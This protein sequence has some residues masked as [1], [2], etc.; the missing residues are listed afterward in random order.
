MFFTRNY[1]LFFFAMLLTACGAPT[2]EGN[3]SAQDGDTTAVGEDQRPDTA[4]YRWTAYES[5]K[6]N[7]GL[8]RPADWRIEETEKSEAFT[9]VNI[10]SP[11]REA[12][13]ELPITIHADAGVSHVSLYPHGFGTELPSGDRATLD[14]F[15]RTAPVDFA[16]AH[17]ESYAFQLEN[18]QTWGY[19]LQPAAPPAGWSEQGFIFAQIAVDNFEARCFDE[20]TGEAI[21]MQACDPMT[22]D[23]IERSGTLQAAEQ[24]AV[25]RILRS[26][27]FPEDGT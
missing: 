12:A 17:E 9:M 20:A 10:F 1:T 19:L 16:L 18:G 5:R 25:R 4:T 22:G 3:S 8:Q 7:V 14:T 11:R 24:E 13:I 21:D 15:D 6:Y 2:G 23:R 26:I 27:H